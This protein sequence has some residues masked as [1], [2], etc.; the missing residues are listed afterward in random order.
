MASG[1]P[2]SA[3]EDG[4]TVVLLVYPR[5]DDTA[6]ECLGGLLCEIVE[7]AKSGR[8]NGSKISL[9]FFTCIVFH[10]SSVAVPYLDCTKYEAANC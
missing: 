6:D 1:R 2:W 10:E 3:C 4:V 5:A 8:E 9:V 7:L